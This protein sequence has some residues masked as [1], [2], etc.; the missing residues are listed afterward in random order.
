MT[1]VVGLFGFD[2][3]SDDDFARVVISQG[4]AS[5]PK[6]DPSATS[7]LPFPFWLTGTA[8]ILTKPTVVVAKILSVVLACGSGL[9]VYG[10]ARL[11]KITPE[12][13]LLGTL[14]WTVVPTG[15]L[16]G[17]ATVPE[18]PT[19]A[20]CASAL[21]LLRRSDIAS[22]F[23]ASAL[24][25]P[26]TLSRYEAWPVAFC[27]AAA[28]LRNAWK[29]DA[30]RGALAASL[31]VACLAC[32]GPLS[33]MGWNHVAHGD[34]L[35]F[36]ARV[37]SYWFAWGGASN[38][39][40]FWLTFAKP[41]AV[42]AIVLAVFVAAVAYNARHS[43]KII[44]W[45]VPAISS[46]VVVAA[47]IAAQCAGAAPTH[48][49]DRSL[50]FLWAVGWMAVMDRGLTAKPLRYTLFAIVL[51]VSVARTMILASNYGVHREDERRVGGWLRDHTQG[52]VL[53]VP[54]DYG[55]FAT[56]A[57]MGP[58]DRLDLTCS[59]DPRD[60]SQPCRTETDNELRDR[61]RKRQ[62]RWLVVSGEARAAARTL[63]E[64]RFEVG[65][66]MVVEYNDP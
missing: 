9:L 58:S 49:P 62:A 6:L 12:S 18:L 3:V 22:A 31:G 16:L 20:L 66:W 43:P 34:A 5:T 25:F 39:V 50:L 1:A 52:R 54:K 42:D 26:A 35:H 41:L 48:H 11:C 56:L 24:V 64:A 46:V 37:S 55:Y 14:G 10:A 57:E 47:L 28:T 8:M 60:R 45:W 13:A 15:V 65:D 51:L 4:F 36:H 32:L 40:D 17:A 19:A 7:W 61:M 63:G 38:I 53:L 44:T 21:L 59:L 2:A 29:S 23:M 27:V 30:T 33:W